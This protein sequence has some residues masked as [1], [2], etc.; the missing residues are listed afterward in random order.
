MI[1]FRN[2]SK[3]FVLNG[4]RKVIADNINVVFPTGKAVAVLGRN[5]AGKSSLL[6]MIAGTLEA[7]SGEILTPGSMSWPVGFAG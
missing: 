6:K 2:L 4:N 1:V 3:A 7:D 5:G